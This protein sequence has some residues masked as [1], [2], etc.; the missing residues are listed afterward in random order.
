MVVSESEEEGK[1]ERRKQKAQGSESVLINRGGQAVL[2]G[3]EP[4]LIAES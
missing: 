2:E 3:A 4:K 1:Q